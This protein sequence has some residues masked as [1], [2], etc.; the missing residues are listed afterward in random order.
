[1]PEACRI[2]PMSATNVRLPSWRGDTLTLIC[3]AG[4]P[5]ACHDFASA[6]AC[7]SAH[8]PMGSIRPVSS[9]IGMNRAG[10]IMPSAGWRQRISASTP[11]MRR[12]CRF[13]FGW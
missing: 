4:R 11:T 7:A 3:T 6:Q 8:L 13:I 9:A 2:E 12:V 1:M 5:Q 10:E